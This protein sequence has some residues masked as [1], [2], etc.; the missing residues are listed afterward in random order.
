MKALI[1]GIGGFVGHYLTEELKSHGY[2][3]A[4][5]DIMPS[6]GLSD[7]EYCEGDLLNADFVADCLRGRRQK[8]KSKIQQRTAQKN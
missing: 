4:G 3:V 6:C 2:E 5:S 7:V 1:F 8:R